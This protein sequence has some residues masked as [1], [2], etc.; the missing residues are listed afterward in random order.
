MPAHSSSPTGGGLF[1]HLRHSGQGKVMSQT[2]RYYKIDQLINDRGIVSFQ[3]PMDEF[4]VSRAKLKRD[5]ARRNPGK[6]PVKNVSVKRLKGVLGAPATGYLQGKPFV[7]QH[8]C[9][10]PNVRAGL[11]GNGDLATAR[12]NPPDVYTK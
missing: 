11:P 7:G 5:L 8:S 4:S 2:E 12:G 9:S 3:T 10:P 6:S 1:I